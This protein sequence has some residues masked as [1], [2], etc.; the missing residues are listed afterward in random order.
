M[1]DTVLSVAW[2]LFWFW[3]NGGMSMRGE[4]FHNQRLWDGQLAPPKG[5]LCETC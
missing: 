5:V 1:V 3:K 4:T 2:E